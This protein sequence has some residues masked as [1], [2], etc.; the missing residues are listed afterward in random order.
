MPRGTHMLVRMMMAA[1]LLGGAVMLFHPD[2]RDAARRLRH[3]DIPH[4]V[5]WESNRGYYAEVIPDPNEN[6]EVDD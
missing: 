1:A 3:G 4:S 2:Y 5:I 6:D